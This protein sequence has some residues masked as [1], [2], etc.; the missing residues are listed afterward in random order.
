MS[1]R[2]P[3]L[4]FADGALIVVAVAATLVG[5]WFVGSAVF[6]WMDGVCG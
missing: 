5:A 2:K 1:D 6:C 3:K 4:T